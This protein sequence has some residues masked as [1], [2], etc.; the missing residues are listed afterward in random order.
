MATSEHDMNTALGL[1][2]GRMRR[3]WVVKSQPL[4][5][6]R[7]SADQPDVLVTEA[8]SP[9]LVIESEVHPARTVEV[10]A[11]SRLG[12]VLSDGGHLLE[13]AI[14]VRIPLRFREAAPGPELEKEWARARDLEFCV[15]NGRKESAAVR[16]PV[17][18]WVSG[19]LR[20]LAAATFL[21]NLQAFE[22]EGLVGL[23]EN[24]VSDAANRLDSRYPRGSA[25]TNRIAAALNQIDDNKRGTRRMATTIVAN[26]LIFQFA[27]GGHTFSGTS[28]QVTVR[29]PNQL[30][31]QSPSGSLTP[32]DVLE[33][34]RRILTVNYWP[35]FDIARQVIEPLD[36]VTASGVLELLAATAEQLHIRGVTK[37]HDLVGTVFQRLIAD[38]EFLATFY[39][40][41]TAAALLASLALPM[42]PALG[43]ADWAEAETVASLS[44]GDFAC[45]T[46]TLLSAAYSRVSLLH[47]LHGGDAGKLHSQMIAHALTGC[48]VLPSAVHLTASMLAGIHPTERII[49]TKL[50]CMPYGKQS[51]GPGGYSLGSLDLA[52]GQDALP[53]MQHS[54]P[55]QVTG[56][57]ASANINPVAVPN[58]SFDLVIMNPPFIRPTN[59]EGTRSNVPNPAFAAFGA[60]PAEQKALAAQAKRIKRL[61]PKPRPGETLV[62]SPVDGN[63]GMASHFIALGHIKA[64]P[65]ATVAMVLPLSAVIGKSWQKSRMLW[66]RS[67]A[68]ILVVTIAAA[69]V[70]DKSFSADTH[71]AEC[72]VIARRSGSGSTRA[73]FLVLN[74][75]PKSTLEATMIA[76]SLRA[77]VKANGLRRLED[78]PN[79]GTPIRIGDDVLGQALDAPI[80]MEGSWHIAGIDDLALAQTCHQLAQGVIWLPGMTESETDRVPTTRLGDIAR[81]G[82]VHRDING[83]A[84]RG[85]FDIENTVSPAPTYPVLWNHEAARERQMLV[86]PDSEGKVRMTGERK[87]QERVNESAAR[88]WSTA[89][90]AHYNLD[91]QLNS[92]SLTV[93]MTERPAIGGRAWP[94]VVF[95][96]RDQEKGFAIWANST[97]GILCHWWQANRQQAGRATTTI[98]AIP[99]LP[100]LDIAALSPGQL[101][102][103]SRVFDDL[104]FQHMLPANELDRDPVRHELDRRLLDD[105]LGLSP[106][107]ASPNG[108]LDLLRRKFAAESSVHGGKKSS[109]ASAR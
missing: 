89:T 100:T 77:E 71:M 93:A 84:F 104:K 2:L 8:G 91:F 105:V 53:T 61:W 74:P 94:S 19:D 14:A 12:K 70:R 10:D 92:Q 11:K 50:L 33:E 79:G 107:L 58:E 29:D 62:Q 102:A 25:P 32:S 80:G 1:C 75:P 4:G 42:A 46:G 16:F 82:P 73:V 35:I 101:S 9:P 86:E 54:T 65:G 68:D 106:D 63:A 90:R 41:P 52:T 96:S 48:D 51:A 109:A 45:G 97:L 56:L 39:T 21:A 43:G 22:V 44:I 72:L 34:W 23:L 60:D 69:A 20:E 13:T 103:A 76:T 85:P 37:S 95:E 108:P 18:G 87:S 59:H 7:G 55:E 24:G 5:S 99:E 31:G 36:V 57:R 3:G 78:P 98:T 28:G 40:T 6:I 66:R 49:G 83:A 15:L 26:A 47:E 30:R 38:R 81:R 17:S 67:Y 64:R 88:I 27:L